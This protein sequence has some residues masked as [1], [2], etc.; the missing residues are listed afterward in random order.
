MKKGCVAPFLSYFKCEEM[1]LSTSVGC[2]ERLREVGSDRNETNCGGLNVDVLTDH[3]LVVGIGLVSDLPVSV[4]IKVFDLEGLDHA[5]GETEGCVVVIETAEENVGNSEN[6]RVTLGVFAVK[7][8]V[9]DKT[10]GVNYEVNVFHVKIVA[11]NQRLNK[12]KIS[13]TLFL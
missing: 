3:T 2:P 5:L 6:V 4:V 10:E 11:V 9:Y 7:V 13:V 8:A 12:R 1:S